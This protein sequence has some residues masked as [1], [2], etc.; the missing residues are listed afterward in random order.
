MSENIF[1]VIC[2]E[3]AKGPMSELHVI[4]GEAFS[5]SRGPLKVHQALENASEYGLLPAYQ[6]LFA[7]FGQRF[8]DAKG[9]ADGSSVTLKHEGVEVK[10]KIKMIGTDLCRVLI[11]RVDR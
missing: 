7:Q 2:A 4:A 6:V 8:P 3:V 11:S 1:D 10:F 5:L 9:F